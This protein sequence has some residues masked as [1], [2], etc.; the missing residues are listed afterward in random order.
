M[1]GFAQQH[2]SEELPELGLARSQAVYH[3]HI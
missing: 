3:L 1:I 2:E